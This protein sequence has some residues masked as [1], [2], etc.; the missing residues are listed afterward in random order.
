ML[1]D[2]DKKIDS[3]QSIML[4]EFDHLESVVQGAAAK[5]NLTEAISVID[6]AI[7]YMNIFMEAQ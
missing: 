4:S 7:K 1:G 5:M 3:L 2:L 6:T